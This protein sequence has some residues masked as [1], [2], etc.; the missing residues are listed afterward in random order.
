LTTARILLFAAL[1]LATQVDCS[2]GGTATRLL[3]VADTGDCT[4]ADL[5]WTDPATG[6]VVL[7]AE[8]VHEGDCVEVTTWRAEWHW[9]WCDAGI[10][11][12]AK[13]TEAERVCP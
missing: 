2:S 3:R 4:V 10:S 6:D 12:F 1:L 5:M 11:D 13:A 7:V 8:D 9:I